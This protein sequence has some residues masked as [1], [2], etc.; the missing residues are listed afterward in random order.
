MAS[1]QKVWQWLVTKGAGRNNDIQQNADELPCNES[2]RVVEH[3]KNEFNDHLGLRREESRSRSGQHY[4]R[5]PLP[6]WLPNYPIVRG[7][8]FFSLEVA[9]SSFYQDA[10]KLIVGGRRDASVYFR[11]IALLSSEPDNK[12]DKHAIG[13]RING[14]TVAHIKREHNILLREQLDEIGV[15][16]DAQCRAMIVG[17][18]NRGHD[19]KGS[20]GVRLDLTWPLEVRNA[21]SEGGLRIKPRVFERD[22]R[23]NEI[24][25][26]DNLCPNCEAPFAT[27]PNKKTKCTKCGSVVFVRTRPFDRQRVLVTESQAALLETEW[28]QYHEA[29]RYTKPPI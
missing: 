10:L 20:F 12:H 7:D 13:V 18:W 24:G 28:S 29:K 8:S 6:D 16:G 21:P 17:G 26:L 11:T 1:I 5:N 9:G 2:P 3:E 23:F 25:R 19:D 14:M 27:R 15:C 22:A 4:Y